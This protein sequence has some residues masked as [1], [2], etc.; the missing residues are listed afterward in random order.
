M[1]DQYPAPQGQPQKDSHGTPSGQQPPAYGAPV[2]QGYSAPGGP[3]YGP[4]PRNSLA[5]IALILGIAGFFTG[6]ASIA[7]IVV[8]H[9]SLSQI[10]KTGEEGR[11]M[12][13]WG[14]IL[15]YVVLIG[16]ILLAVGFAVLFGALASSGQLDYSTY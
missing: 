6:V 5:L 11:G 16:G 9:I 7:A 3:G 2:G 13:L 8:G 12:A 1:T 4:A 10:K 14:T 15:G